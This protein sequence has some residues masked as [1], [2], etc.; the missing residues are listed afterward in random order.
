MS[1]R[2]FV[3]TNVLLYA[4]E[5]SGG[6]DAAKTRAALEVLRG[7]TVGLSTQVLGEFYHAATHRRRAH[8][9]TTD[10]AMAWVQLWKKHRVATITVPHVDLALEISRRYQTGYYDALILSAARFLGCDVVYS[11]DLND[12]QD[13]GGVTVLNPFR[14]K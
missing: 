8:P 4:I 14:E 12:G 5:G 10:E 11:E 1:D 13:Y 2:V 9:L 6:A 7:R 3:D